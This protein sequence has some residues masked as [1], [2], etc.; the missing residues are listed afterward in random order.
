MG[1]PLVPVGILLPDPRH[2]TSPHF[3][4][5]EPC[6]PDHT[7]VLEVDD[8]QPPF[9]LLLPVI[10]EGTLE[11]VGRLDSVS[12]VERDQLRILQNYT[13]DATLQL[14]IEGTLADYDRHFTTVHPMNISDGE[15][16]DVG[17]S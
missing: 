10:A 12:P 13:L 16:R 1:R 3:R 7:L 5:I 4:A 17:P 2:Q 14:S 9:E 8:S 15:F 6:V 11:F